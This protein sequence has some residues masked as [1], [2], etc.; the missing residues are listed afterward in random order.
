M[1]DMSADSKPFDSF[2]MIKWTW[3]AIEAKKIDWLTCHPYQLLRGSS[4]D[5]PWGQ[6]AWLTSWQKNWWLSLV[7]VYS[8]KVN[9]Y[10]I[11]NFANLILDSK[12][13][14]NEE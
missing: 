11:F 5:N 2:A 10:K 8:K 13:V 3:I 14:F 4:V 12:Y 9:K 1:S 6:V 7:V